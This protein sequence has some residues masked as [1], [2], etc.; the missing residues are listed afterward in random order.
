MEYGIEDPGTSSKLVGN[1][2][3]GSK[4]NEN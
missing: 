3:T 1:E 4:F 2:T